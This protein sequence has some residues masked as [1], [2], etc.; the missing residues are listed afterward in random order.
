MK[1]VDRSQVGQNQEPR[2]LAEPHFLSTRR[3]FVSYPHPIGF[4]MLEVNSVNRG[5]SQ[6]S[7]FLVLTKSQLGGMKMMVNNLSFHGNEKLQGTAYD[8]HCQRRIYTTSMKK[9][10][11]KDKQ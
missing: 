8:K 1:E 11:C 4:V 7:R 9:Q 3:V 6:R 2:P 5:L 10:K